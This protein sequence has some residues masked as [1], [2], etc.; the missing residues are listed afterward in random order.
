MSEGERFVRVPTQL[1]E[2]LLRSRLN[3]TE[4]RI[5]LWVA[6]QTYG[7]NRQTTPFSWYRIAMELAMDRGGIVRAGRH[8]LRTGI[9]CLAGDEIGIQPNDDLR[10]QTRLP[11]SK[12]EAMTSIST[13]IRDD[14]SHRKPVTGIIASDD[15]CQRNRCQESSLFRRAKDILIDIIKTKK[16]SRARRNDDW[17]HRFGNGAD[18]EPH[19]PA[20]AARPIPGK[21]DGLSQN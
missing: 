19:H 2:T 13:S 7:W 20:G 5:V 3:G 18:N 11:E 1:L 21:Y 14:K 17:H 10:F 12:P 8:L 16:D 15:A 6:R 9:L 4:L